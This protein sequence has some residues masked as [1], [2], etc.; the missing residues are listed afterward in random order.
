MQFHLVEGKNQTSKKLNAIHKG[1][2]YQDIED[3]NQTI[4]QLSINRRA[5]YEDLGD[6]HH[7][8]NDSTLEDSRNKRSRDEDGGAGPSGE[9]Y[10]I[11]EPPSKDL[12]DVWLILK[13]FVQ[14]MF[15]LFCL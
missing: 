11:D 15:R 1:S 10:F 7:D 8:L 13:N 3:L 14:G 2:S 6:P 12:E 5:L 4:T 9:D